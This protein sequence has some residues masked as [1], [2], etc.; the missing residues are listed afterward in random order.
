MDEIPAGLEAALEG[1][2][3]IE[4]EVGRGGMATVYLA[5]DVKHDRQVALKELKPELAVVVG[6]ERFLTEIKTT[7]RLQHPHILPL[8]DSG[9]ADSFLF[10]VM[11]F[12]EGETLRDRLDR[13]KQLPVDE[14]VR[15]ASEIADALDYAHGR[16]IVH[17]DI[18]PANILLQNG[19]VLVADFGIALAVTA[20]GA[21][22]LTE[23]G[24]S[25]GTPQYMSP[26]QA[27][28]D[29]N[30]D[31]RSDVYSLACIAYE[32]LSGDPPHSASTAQAILGKVLTEVPK[33]LTEV[34]RTGPDHVA[35]AVQVGL[36][37]LPAD[38]F[39]SAR[40]FRDALVGA[41]PVPGR[42][43]TATRATGAAPGAWSAAR[44]VRP[45]AAFTGGVAVALAGFALWG[46]DG[47]ETLEEPEVDVLS[48]QLPPDQE[49]SV[50]HDQ[51][52]FD[53]SDDGR[54]I[55]WTGPAGAAGRRAYYR[56][57]DDLTIHSIPEVDGFEMSWLEL[58]PDGSEIAVLRGDGLWVS[59][60]DG[61]GTS[62]RIFEGDLWSWAWGG[63]GSWVLAQ[64]F[65]GLVRVSAPGAD[66]EPLTYLE[67]DEVTHQFPQVL[68]DGES[69]LFSVGTHHFWS[70]HIEVAR[71]AGD[72]LVRKIVLDDAYSAR[73]TESGHLVFG[74]E[75]QIVAVPFDLETLETTG[76]EVT[77]VSGVERDASG[78]VTQFAVGLD[79]TIV[80][81]PAQGLAETRLAWIGPDGSLEWLEVPRSSY[82][83]ASAS[84]DLQ[85]L[86]VVARSP[87]DR[88]PQVQVI[89][90][91][92]GVPTR[93]TSG[94]TQLDVVWSPD[95]ERLV[96][97]STREGFL[98]L[99]E[100]SLAGGGAIRRLTEADADQHP[101]S[102]SQ[103]G[104]VAYFERRRFDQRRSFLIRAADADP[105][106]MP[107][108]PEGVWQSEPA[109]SPDGRWLAL[110]TDAGVVI[111][112]VDG[113]TPRQVSS[114]PSRG[115]MWGSDSRRLY[116]WDGV[117]RVLR[118][119]V[120]PE[121]EL[122][123]ETEV[124]STGE[125]LEL[126]GHSPLSVASDGRVLLVLKERRTEPIE[127]V[128]SQGL[129]HR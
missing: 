86:A 38:R 107:V 42:A 25:V 114:G 104:G 68:P 62:Q 116:F 117:G 88:R 106:P 124:F 13:E 76:P 75:D 17:R 27:T 28:G 113:G 127:A 67:G 66:P 44:L 49:I 110:R 29:R 82:F 118:V 112:P 77:L 26:E 120:G 59:R 1:R 122:G 19:R 93:I 10:Y 94:A 9:E 109:L 6:A 99:F 91:D 129:L 24:L 98:N 50:D 111:R 119:S 108:T 4:R 30:L 96:F 64:P 54:V 56:R 97:N 71:P 80:H 53:I 32:M 65:D 12:V 20:A 35:A 16:E 43:A 45:L 23:T 8:F 18:K 78:A 115:P 15:I 85:S 41:R 83:I 63:G 74:R 55:A 60:L 69:I 33:G 58:S 37:K 3:D 46:P 34:R 14:A 39:A 2:Y 105:R 22:R 95:G 81:L 102:W 40:D 92:R 101:A 48:F 100:A 7:A 11:P 36:E 72:S 31:G 103:D 52:L 57:L 126:M 5:E 47:A 79:G 121:G 90:L 61:T 73:Y 128:V 84:P 51:L 70:S 21:S 125:N 89:D 123:R 87:S